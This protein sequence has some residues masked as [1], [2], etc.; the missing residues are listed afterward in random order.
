MKKLINF[1]SNWINLSTF[2]TLILVAPII[3][4]VINALGTQSD[5]LVHLKETVLNDYIINTIILLIAVSLLALIFGVGSAYFV[6]F[7]DF[8]FSKFF[9]IVL[10]LPFLV[11]SYILGFIYSD[12]FGFYGVVHLF[13]MDM[14][15]KHYFDILNMNSVIV[16]LS[17]ALYPYIY[18]IV[19][20]SFSK[21]SSFLLNPALSL[22]ANRLKIFYRVILPLSRPAIIGALSL[23]MMETISEY[24]L[25]KYYG[26]DT[27]STAVF[28]AWFGLN[29]PNSAAYISTIAMVMVF[30]ILIVEKLNRGNAKYKIESAP[31]PIKK[32]KP[33]K[34][35]QI[36]IIGFLSIPF[37]LGFLIP[38]LWV[39][40]YSFE[41]YALI[42][43]NEF[44]TT[45]LNSFIAAFISSTIIMSIAVLLG[46]SARV[47]DNSYMKYLLKVATLG[48]SIPGAV[49]A[50]GIIILSTSIDNYFI[51]HFKIDGLVLGGTLIILCFGYTARFLA[52]GLNSVESSFEK[53]GFGVNKASRSLNKS[54]F[55][56]LMK[57][58][59]PLIKSG[60]VAGFILVFIDIL[61]ELPAT[62]ILRP[63][64]YDTLATKTYELASIE[65]VQESSI[66][67]LSIV[68]VSI[69]PIIFILRNYK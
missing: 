56:T 59:L 20:S 37:I 44:I 41:H 43:Q 39:L 16:I 17:L 52:V 21:N 5:T 47:F 14:G 35:G 42:L 67:A 40:F 2:I 23:V 6:T 57:I 34:I 29:D 31:T 27:L 61:K 62:L 68:V 10:V 25:V 69:I 19:K 1:S 46:Y 32:I 38:I 9:G 33:T 36:S 15:G 55:Q 64:N 8:K 54:L 63:F 58:D 60:V 4:I 50:V 26:V 53:I 65:M 3:L 13:F 51:E 24:G 48:Y 30:T 66:Y 12:I 28:T 7:Y 45:V 18:L 22:G 11:P 49:I